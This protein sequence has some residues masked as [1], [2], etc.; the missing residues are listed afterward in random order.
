MSEIDERDTAI[1]LAKLDR[2]IDIKCI[3]LKEKTQEMKLK[4]LFFTGCIVI[5]FIF[6]LQAV[7]SIFDVNNLFIILI[8][9]TVALVVIPVVLNLTRGVMTK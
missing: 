5:M 3:E 2:E 8:Y 1:L 4:R 6:L 9:Q 7:F